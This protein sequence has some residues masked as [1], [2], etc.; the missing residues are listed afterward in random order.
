MSAWAVPRRYP[1]LPMHQRRRLLAAVACY[2]AARA[3]IP[4]AVLVAHRWAVLY[5]CMKCVVQGVTRR[6]ICTNG[7]LGGAQEVPLAAHASTEALAGGGGV[8]SSRTC[9]HPLGGVGG[10]SMG[11]VVCMHEVRCSGRHPQTDLHQ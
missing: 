2:Q 4:L 3:T 5:A 1:S 6:R 10:S 9:N 11:G 7:C 8:L